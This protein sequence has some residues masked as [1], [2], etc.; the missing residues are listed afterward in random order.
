MKKLIVLA[1]VV[2]VFLSACSSG[3]NSSSTPQSVVP[4]STPAPVSSTP[5]E[6]ESEPE[7]TSSDEGD[8][9]NYH[10]KILDATYGVDYAGKPIVVVNLEFTN[11]SAST[12]AFLFTTDVKAFQDGVELDGLVMVMDS[13]VYD[14]SLA[15]KELKT[16]ATLVVQSAFHLSSESPIEVE[17][18]ELMAFGNTT[19]LT[20]TFTK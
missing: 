7:P 8:I 19:T 14:A 12:A 16:G 15:Q 5:P 17:V 13:S 3:N 9:G 20:K 1:L 18:T 6:P 4:E 2:A 11:N 10:V